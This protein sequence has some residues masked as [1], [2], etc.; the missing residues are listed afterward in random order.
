MRIPVPGLTVV[1]I[2]AL[3]GCTSTSAHAQTLEVG[4]SIGIGAPGSEG[5]L[6]TLSA[7]VVPAVHVSI[8]PGDR[9]EV[10]IRAAFLAGPS[11]PTTTTYTR[12]VPRPEP[13][14]QTVRIDVIGR[15]GM[16]R[17]TALDVV[18][19]AGAGRARPFIGAGIGSISSTH[20]RSCDVA[21]CEAILGF[22]LGTSTAGAGDVIAIAGV[23]VA[24][25]PHS[26][27]R[28]AVHFHRPAGENLSMFE[29]SFMAGYKF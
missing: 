2:T 29:M 1:L 17:Y 9:L 27:L 16:R 22:A 10:S 12:C 4:G 3:G 8:W 25:T 20:T 6:V 28:G 5:S 18:Y 13:G 23:A 26:I 19:H 7:R 11:G 24:V 15:A 21:G 14:C